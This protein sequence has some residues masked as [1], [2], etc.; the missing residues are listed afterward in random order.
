MRQEKK[1]SS[2]LISSFRP[3]SGGSRNSDQTDFITSKDLHPSNTDSAFTTKNA[4][5]EAVGDLLTL[6]LTMKTSPHPHSHPLKHSPPIPLTTS[7]SQLQQQTNNSNNN[8]RNWLR[9]F[10]LTYRPPSD[11]VPSP[12]FL[13]WLLQCYNSNCLPQS[14]QQQY[15]AEL[16]DLELPEEVPSPFNLSD[17]PLVDLLEDLQEAEN[18]GVVAALLLGEE[19]PLEEGEILAIPEVEDLP[20]PLEAD[21]REE[22][23]HSYHLVEPLEEGEIAN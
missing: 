19:D 14:L 20:D 13:R 16:L 2:P 8:L 18:L 12:T 10:P 7:T 22:E 23:D 5:T 3:F 17:Y 11:P 1:F 4:S 15:W 21:P 9:T 6:T